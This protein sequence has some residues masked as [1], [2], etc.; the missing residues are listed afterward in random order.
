MALPYEVIVTHQHDL[1]FALDI[2]S[3]SIGSIFGA[4]IASARR[5]PLIGVLIVAV[6][7]GMGGSILRDIL[8]NAPLNSLVHP[9]YIISALI[10]TVVGAVAGHWLLKPRWLI[11]MMDTVVMGLFVVLGTEKAF[12]FGMPPM[13]AV[14]IGMITAIGGGIVADLLLGQKPDIMS[15]GPW[16]ASI[17]LVGAFWFVFTANMGNLKFAEYTTIA[18]CV[19]IRGMVLWRKWEAPLPEHLTSTKWMKLPNR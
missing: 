1:P 4:T 6:F 12:M 11:L 8:L 14:F 10:C 9:Q 16:N 5:T 13:S 2:F 18:L 3:V 17:A 15:P 19:G 7:M